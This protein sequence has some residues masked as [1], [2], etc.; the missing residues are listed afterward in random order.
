MGSY[1]NLRPTKPRPVATSSVDGRIRISY[2]SI[3]L[4]VTVV[5]GKVEFSLEL[6]GVEAVTLLITHL[7]DL[8]FELIN[9]ALL[10]S[11]LLI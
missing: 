9:T 11:H 6:G 2:Q 7:R 1:R 5:P 10:V 3:F 8:S 4:L